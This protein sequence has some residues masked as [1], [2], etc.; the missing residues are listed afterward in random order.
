MTEDKRYLTQEDIPEID[1][2]CYVTRSGEVWQWSR[3]YKKMV[4]RSVHLE[5]KHKYCRVGLSLVKGAKY[6]C[7]SL[8][9]P[10]L[11][12]RC[13]TDENDL[14]NNIY[15][16]YHDGDPN[17]CSFDNLYR[18]GGYIRQVEPEEIIG[19]PR[20]RRS[21]RTPVYRPMKN[22]GLQ[23]KEN[24][25]LLSDYDSVMTFLDM[26]D[27]HRESVLADTQLTI[28]TTDWTADQ[29]RKLLK[30]K[31]RLDDALIK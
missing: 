21:N 8:C 28:D 19:V 1:T 10:S 23:E 27:E 17:N 5:R 20:R 18:T 3:R 29:L 12:Y 4:K 11:V 25:L 22:Y 13:F 26:Q 16:N 30:M 14:P 7:T 15:I 9:L 31:A 6:N 2:P 24:V